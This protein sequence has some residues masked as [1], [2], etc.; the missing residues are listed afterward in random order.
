[1]AAKTS[2]VN[3]R[4]SLVLVDGRQITGTLLAQDSHMNLVVSGAT[5]TRTNKNGDHTRGLPLVI[6]RGHT[7]ISLSQ[8]QEPL[9]AMA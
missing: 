2:L 8:S 4:I 5:E 1:M 3:K 9:S 7:V 6:L